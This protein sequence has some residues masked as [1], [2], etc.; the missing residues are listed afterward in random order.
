MCST[1]I[2]DPVGEA[3]TATQFTAGLIAAIPLE[4]EI[5][6]IRD[7][8]ALR[9]HVK[10]P[11]Q[12]VQISVPRASHLRKLDAIDDGINI[13]YQFM[14]KSKLFELNIFVFLDPGNKGFNLRLLTK[15]LISHQ[16]WTAQCPI[17]ISLCL[18]VPD[19]IGAGKKE[20]VVI[21][22]CKPVKVNVL[23]IAIKRGI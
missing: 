4:A 20:P 3:E 5:M 7:P 17:E 12:L 22:L 16:V 8:S 21:D 2:I 18:A 13:Y 15:V 11:D 10:Y 23:P 1:Q 14:C 6:N 9:V 19:Q